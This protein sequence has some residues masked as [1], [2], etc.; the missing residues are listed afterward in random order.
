M[1]RMLEFLIDTDLKYVYDSGQIKQMVSGWEGD[2][3]IWGYY[4]IEGNI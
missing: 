1:H 2:G 4:L 3:D